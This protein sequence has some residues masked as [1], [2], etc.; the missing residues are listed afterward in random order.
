MDGGAWKVTVHG[1]TKGSGMTA[2]RK[3]LQSKCSHCKRAEVSL[4]AINL[5][6]ALKLNAFYRDRGNRVEET[7]RLPVSFLDSF[8][9]LLLSCVQFQLPGARTPKPRLSDALGLSCATLGQILTL[10]FP[11]PI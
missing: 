4:Q 5:Q 9:L 10:V 7:S 2:C 11:S 6:L 1:V 8:C 3:Q